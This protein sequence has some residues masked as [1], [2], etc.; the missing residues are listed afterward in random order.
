MNRSGYTLIELVLVVFLVGLMLFLAVPKVR[1]SLIND[2]LAASV[3]KTVGMA[4]GL[5][6]DAVREQL[7]YVLQFDLKNNAFWT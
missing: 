6:A 4:R 2:T 3:R 7:D 5:R 1:D